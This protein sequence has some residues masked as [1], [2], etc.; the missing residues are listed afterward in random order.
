MKGHEGQGLGKSIVQTLRQISEAAG[1]Y[2]TILDCKEDLLPFYA[3]SGFEKKEVQ[4]VCYNE[5]QIEANRLKN[6]LL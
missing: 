5:A 2:K 3:K 1:C 6:A 4:A